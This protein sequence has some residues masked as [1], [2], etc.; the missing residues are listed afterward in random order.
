MAKKY[1]YIPSNRLKGPAKNLEGKIFKYLTVTKVLGTSIS[2]KCL[3]WECVCQ[4]G[5][6]IEALSVNLLSGNTKSC[7]CFQKE[8]I[9]NLR[10][11]NPPAG[12]L[13]K[14][15]AAAK[16]IY[17]T[18][19]NTALKMKREFSLTQED[20]IILI[21]K[22]CDYC[23]IEPKKLVKNGHD[24]LNGSFMA[25]GLDRIDSSKGYTKDNVSPCC[26]TCN[27]A[28]NAMPVEEFL[29]W[30]KRVNDHQEK[31]K[32]EQILIQRKIDE[33]NRE[34]ERIATKELNKRLIE[35]GI[36]RPFNEIY[37]DYLKSKEENE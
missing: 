31:L 20:F 12:Q 10:K 19:K 1:N 2:N 3:V 35:K 33:E 23:G 5:A 25:N 7:G 9:S 27:I 17:N 29:I 37:E 13:A 21:K 18:Y 32:W 36:S 15:E 16:H 6:I 11:G 22:P 30:I 14:G 24:N 4:C 8:I 34:K 26:R 28:K